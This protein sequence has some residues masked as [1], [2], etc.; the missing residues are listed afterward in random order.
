[1]PSNMKRSISLEEKAT[2]EVSSV[3][4]LQVHVFQ[5]VLLEHFAFSASDVFP[6]P[7]VV[8]FLFERDEDFDQ[9]VVLLP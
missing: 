5:V 7:V 2:R 6:Q 9:Q 1:M 4:E 3:G 8:G